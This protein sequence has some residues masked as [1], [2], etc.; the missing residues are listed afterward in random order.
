MSNP[1]SVP[2]LS[3]FVKKGNMIFT[4]GQV[5]LKDGKLIE[6]SVKD[7]AHQVM[8]NLKNVLEKAGVTFNDVVKTTIYTTDMSIYGEIN[9]IYASYFSGTFPA[10]EVIGVKE[11]P[12]GAKIEISMVAIEE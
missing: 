5:Y 11:L 4:S 8:T 2:P 10:R 3:P 1:A 6:G 9:E 12:L 7:Q